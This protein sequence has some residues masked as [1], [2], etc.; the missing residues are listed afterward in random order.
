MLQKLQEPLVIKQRKSVVER[1]EIDYE[2]V[3]GIDC[4]AVPGRGG[5]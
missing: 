5:V 4:E 1:A 2:Q 3:R